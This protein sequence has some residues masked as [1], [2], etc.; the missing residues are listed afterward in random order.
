MTMTGQG[1]L[2]ETSRV[3]EPRPAAVLSFEAG[4]AAR[5]E[6]GRA[7][8]CL[9]SLQPVRRLSSREVAHR[10]RMLRHLASQ[11]EGRV[12]AQR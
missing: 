2:F 3:L 8:A 12:A 10:E 1:N 4:R 7:P 9:G 6:A 11:P 5:G